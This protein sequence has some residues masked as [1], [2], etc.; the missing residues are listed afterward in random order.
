MELKMPFDQD[1]T[2]ENDEVFV[3]L[4]LIRYWYG[5]VVYGY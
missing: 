1:E 2:P 5:N 3:F 4:L